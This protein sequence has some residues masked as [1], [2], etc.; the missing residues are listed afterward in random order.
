MTT[1]QFKELKVGDTFTFN[2]IEYVR[3]ADEKI[4]CCRSNNAALVSE[5]KTKS[6]V[7]PLS[8]VQVNDQ[9]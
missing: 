3:I 7:P 6:F 4:S 1:K 9:L 2:N 8:E 5:A